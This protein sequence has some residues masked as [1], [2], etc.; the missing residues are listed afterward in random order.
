MTFNGSSEEFTQPLS[1]AA[2]PGGEPT[3]AG[4]TNFAYVAYRG[5]LDNRIRTIR[6]TTS[7]GWEAEQL[8]QWIDGGIKKDLPKSIRPV[9]C[10]FPFCT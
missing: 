8:A 6:F 9:N 10:I 2:L 1:L 5:R 3:L 7:G 4:E